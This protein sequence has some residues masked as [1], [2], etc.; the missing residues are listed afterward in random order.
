MK[1]A[2]IMKSKGIVAFTPIAKKRK[3]PKMF[4]NRYTCNEKRMNEIRAMAE[5]SGLSISVL[6]SQMVDFAMQHYQPKEKNDE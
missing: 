3:K 1:K 5:A 6:L 4:N 2:D